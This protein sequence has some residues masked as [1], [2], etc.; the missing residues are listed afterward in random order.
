MSHKMRK[1]VFISFLQWKHF[2]RTAHEAWYYLFTWLLALEWSIFLKGKSNEEISWYL[3][4]SSTCIFESWNQTRTDLLSK[5][6]FSIT[7]CVNC[8]VVISSTPGIFG[9]SMLKLCNLCWCVCVYRHWTSSRLCCQVWETLGNTV[10][11]PQASRPLPL[12]FTL[13]TLPTDSC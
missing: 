8:F 4:S 7:K 6:F 2:I 11:K 10:H 12:S 1:S 3:I 5:Y 13:S 9:L